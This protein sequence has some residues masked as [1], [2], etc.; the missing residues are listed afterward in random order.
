MPVTIKTNY[1]NPGAIPAAINQVQANPSALS[2]GYQAEAQSVNQIGESLQH[3]A[4]GM[5]YM[6]GEDVRAEKRD[7]YI[8]M[9]Q[10]EHAAKAAASM[11]EQQNKLY[12]QSA[13]IQAQMQLNQANDQALKQAQ[14]GGNVANDALQSY[15]KIIKPYV[16]GA[17]TPEAAM[18]TQ[19]HLSKHLPN[20]QAWGYKA[21]NVIDTNFS[22]NQLSSDSQSLA[23]DASRD[24]SQVNAL[25]G[26][27]HSKADAMK[28]AGINSP[29]IDT[30]VSSG[31]LAIQKSAMLSI[32]DSSPQTA[33]TKLMQGDF[34]AFLAKDPGFNHTL[35]KRIDSSFK[36]VFSV[37]DKNVENI[38]AAVTT[39]LQPPLDAHDKLQ[40][41]L[42][43]VKAYGGG[44]D[45]IKA[46][47]L[48]DKAM[49][50]AKLIDYQQ[51]IQGSSPEQ[52]HAIKLGVLGAQ[53]HMPGDPA[54]V[55]ANKGLMKL[56][57]NRESIF[58]NSPMDVEI[59]DGTIK[60]PTVKLSTDL[61][62]DPQAL[63]KLV[64][65]RTT[66]QGVLGARNYRDGKGNPNTNPFTNSE[67]Q[68]FANSVQGLDPV[69]KINA[70]QF[71]NQMPA[72]LA[73]PLLKK[74][75]DKT[76][77]SNALGLA[78]KL[79][80]YEP[81]LAKDIA[82]GQSY[83]AGDDKL[84][85]KAKLKEVS[86][87]LQA[88]LQGLFSN[89][90][91][92]MRQYMSASQALLAKQVMTNGTSYADGILNSQDIQNS[93]KRT[94]GVESLKAAD[95]SF[96]GSSYSTVMPYVPVTE[97]RKPDEPL[98][99]AQY[100]RMTADEFTKSVDSIKDYGTLTAYGNGVPV[101]ALTGKTID[102][103]KSNL[104]MFKWI[105]AGQDGMYEL[106]VPSKSGDRVMRN[107][108]DGTKFTFNLKQYIAQNG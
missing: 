89:D 68:D 1:I 67:V 4:G 53:A 80:P 24:P 83:I 66:V 105:P 106:H 41:A 78:I 12:V 98:D 42:S 44:P 108:H 54:T 22:I 43:V 59:A 81:Q 36:G 38:M 65:E 97:A 85:E 25:V 93:F 49:A 104:S 8:A 35:Q 14:P 20:V 45:D 79:M 40:D 30:H 90:P 74:V 92:L 18:Q 19:L 100:R 71:T 3:A 75:S 73:E 62:Q 64:A 34:D 48:N 91:Q 72:E 26:M 99:K 102:L 58:K 10:A 82:Q 32:A 9:K 86:S 16:D 29:H 96:F 76:D 23:A 13:S 95:G 52:L 56:I 31:E 101:D 46:N 5:N 11:Q 6:L 21:Q 84:V 37:A 103:E 27:L 17:P 28:A 2:A 39:G 70:L 33:Q 69:A 50:A 60:E 87:A 61:N 94:L 47:A 55:M 51:G 88:N 57:S 107:D 63:S 15:Y 7:Q 77:H